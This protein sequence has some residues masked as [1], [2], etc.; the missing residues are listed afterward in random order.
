MPVNTIA[1]ARRLRDT[2]LSAAQAEAIA[3]EIGTSLSEGAATK[4]DIDALGHRLEA[5]EQRLT[6]KIEASRSSMLTWIVSVILAGAG[7]LIA[8]QRLR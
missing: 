8:I 6:A 2:D 3:E 7:L 4:T 5:M 1:I